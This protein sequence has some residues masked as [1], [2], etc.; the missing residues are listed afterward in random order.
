MSKQ[1]AKEIAKSLD[2]KPHPE[3]GY[4]RETYRSGGKFGGRSCST[5]IYFMLVPESFSALHRID[6]DELWHFYAGDPI[7]IVQILD[8]GSVIKTVIGSN[9]ANGQVP[10]YVMPA[11]DW[12]GSYLN[13][14]GSWALVGCTVSP[15]FEFSKFELGNRETLLKKFPSARNEIMKLT[16]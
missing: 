6:S 1:T 4:Y 5:A 7:T 8:E 12:F 15:G 11:G 10:Q 9:F 2:L 3:G 14:G 13:E 16:R